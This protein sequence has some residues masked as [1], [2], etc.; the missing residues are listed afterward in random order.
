MSSIITLNP[1]VN[2]ATIVGEN[3]EFIAPQGEDNIINAHGDCDV[4]IFG[5]SEDDAI[6]S[7]GPGDAS[8]FGGDGHDTITTG[9]ADDIIQGGE[10]DDVI[11]S[12]PGADFIFG[13]DGRDTIRSGQSGSIFHPEGDII[14]GGDG[15]DL[16]EFQQ[17]EFGGAI[18]QIVD[19]QADGFHD[20][21]RIMGVTDGDVTYDPDTGLVSIN[22]EAVIDIGTG[23]GVD[24]NEVGDNTWEIF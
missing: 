8:I 23:L 10:G 12:G 9:L 21:I 18:D 6:T 15:E 20:L 1:G 14:S 11:S 24:V 16:F 3:I 22:G 19:F 17:N 5:G 7:T 2:Q 4:T 13:G